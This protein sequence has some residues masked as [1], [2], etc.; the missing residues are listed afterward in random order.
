MKRR[1][2]DPGR[3]L[4]AA[5]SRVMSDKVWLHARETIALELKHLK[6]MNQIRLDHTATCPHCENSAPMLCGSKNHQLKLRLEALDATAALLVIERAADSCSAEQLTETMYPL[7]LKVGKRMILPSKISR[8]VTER[9][10][11]GLSH[12]N[13]TSSRNDWSPK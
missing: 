1:P 5:T 7:T 4:S 11:Y 9:R 8:Y 3:L 2:E 6:A 12:D 10:R 13:L